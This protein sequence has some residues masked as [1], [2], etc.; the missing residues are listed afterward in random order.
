MREQTNMS[1]IDMSKRSALAGLLVLCSGMMACEQ[2]N[3]EDPAYIVTQMETGDATARRIAFGHLDALEDDKKMAAVP[4]LTKL[5]L[6]GADD[7][8][9]YIDTLL[10]LRAPEAKDAYL[11]EVKTN[12]NEKG[13]AAAEV[14]GEI[15]AKEAIPAMT[16]LYKS[17]DSSQ[18]KEGILRGFTYMPDAAMVPVLVET[19]KLDADNN[20]IALHSYSCD[21]LGDIAL[22]NP[23]ALD[24]DATATLVRAMFLTNNKNQNIAAECGIAV[25]K[26][27]APAIPELVKT[28]KLENQPVQQ[29]MLGYK[30]PTNQPRWVAATRLGS[31]QAK[32][33]V[34]LAVEN[35]PAKRDIPE[36]ASTSRDKAIGW[37][38]MEGQ[39]ISEEMLA[40][41]DIGSSDAR[42]VL[43]KAMQGEYDE[44]WS[45]IK[46]G[47]GGLAFVQFRQ[48]AARAL[49]RIGD[50]SVTSNI[51]ESAQDMK[52]FSWVVDNAKAVAAH[53]KTK[54]PSAAELYSYN[55]TLAQAYANLSEASGKADY[56][57]WI[58]SVE[59]AD[60]KKELEKMLPAFDLQ[61][62]CAGKGDAAAQAKCYGEKATDSDPVLH[63]KAIYELT[64]LP[65]EAAAPVIAEKLSTDNLTARELLAFAAYRLPS[66]QA[67]TTAEKLLEDESS[68]TGDDYRLDRRRLKYLAA[69][70]KNNT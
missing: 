33:L 68:R 38:T 26:L 52:T 14:L 49:N 56:E 45:E 6:E 58:A 8:D 70:L 69:W 62:T 51:L 43:V 46:N 18:V 64:R 28:Y 37:L 60:L 54:L 25:Q 23:G 10:V 17:T 29:L 48:D 47:V 32:E 53:N 55:V 41:G 30:F 15:K 3:W 61:A 12:K 13:G 36:T 34:P 9:K 57:K 63:Q 24:A 2:P 59:D 50:R 7:Q 42:D 5:Y 27:G 31:L 16:E 44:S 35:I 65:A 20:P 39:L 66:K 19:L 40:L 21:I 67:L 11:A 1:K 4:V 22:Q